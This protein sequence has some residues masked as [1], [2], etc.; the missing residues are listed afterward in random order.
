M[1]SYSVNGNMV[2][3]RMGE[4]EQRFTNVVRGF[5]PCMTLKGGTTLVKSNYI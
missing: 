5:S 2:V 1:V 3:G 4:A